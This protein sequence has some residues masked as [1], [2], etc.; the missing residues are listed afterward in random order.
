MSAEDDED[1][2]PGI[3]EWV[4]TF[5]DM[6]SLLLTF[7][8]M[9]VSLSEVKEDKKYQALVESI[10]Q[11]FGYQPTRASVLPGPSKPRNSAIAKLATRGRAQ[12]KDTM[13]GG[14]KVV[15]PVGE[16]KRVRI[17]RP[18]SSKTVGSAIVFDVGSNE[19]SEA[20]QVILQ[21]ETFRRLRGKPQKIEIRGHTSRN[22][23]EAAEHSG[24]YWHL[25][26]ERCR[27]TKKFMVARLGL[28]P[29]RIRISVA[30]P[31]EPY[32]IGT[33][34]QRMKENPRVEIFLLDEIVSDWAG[35][36]EERKKQISDN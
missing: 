36:E 23:L 15:A 32:H 10:Q 17:V 13:R 25:A 19:L 20:H 12:R 27:N 28:N 1:D 22:P 16:N 33:D 9:L 21:D 8:I 31:H 34:P 5:G 14:D 29:A 35:T 7:F 18:G 26:Y 11:Q 3:P 30:G 4:V 2:A 24:D 6:M